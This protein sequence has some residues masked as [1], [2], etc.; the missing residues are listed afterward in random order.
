MDE[1]C[2]LEIRDFSGGDTMEGADQTAEQMGIIIGPTLIVDDQTIVNVVKPDGRIARMS[3]SPRKNRITLSAG[4][5]EWKTLALHYL[6][7]T[8][9][10][11][12]WPESRP[13]ETSNESLAVIDKRFTAPWHEEAL[14]MR[15][16]VYSQQQIAA[17]AGV[18]RS[19]VNR[20]FSVREEALSGPSDEFNDPRK[21][22][23]IRE[24]I[25][26]DA[27]PEALR[28]FA[29]GEIDR[30]EMMRRITPSTRLDKA[31]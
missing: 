9:P 29:A 10:D 26:R 4:D 21:P 24:V 25:K 31:A 12:Q 8:R 6:L 14:E 11:F 2:L 13:S 1:A 22:R 7:E 28:A 19:R 16:L 27:M 30:A 17:R 23:A 15:D 5:S 20:L 3:D 18:D